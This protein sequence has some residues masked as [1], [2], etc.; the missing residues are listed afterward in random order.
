MVKA[1]AT[2]AGFIRPTELRPPEADA[3]AVRCCGKRRLL[4]VKMLRSFVYV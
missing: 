3:L 1:G 2:R 4:A